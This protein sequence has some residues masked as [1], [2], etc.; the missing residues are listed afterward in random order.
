MW[1]V[2]EVTTL[3]IRLDTIH[4][5]NYGHDLEVAQYPIYTVGIKPIQCAETVIFSSTPPLPHTR[6]SHCYRNASVKSRIFKTKLES[7][8]LRDSPWISG[9]RVH[10][11]S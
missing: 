6:A 10:H 4:H 8:Y 5:V 2:Y 11:V 9:H 7:L 3:H 1:T